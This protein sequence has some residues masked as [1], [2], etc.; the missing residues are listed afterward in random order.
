MN[1]GVQ[2]F[3]VRDY[4]GTKERVKDTFSKIKATAYDSVQS[5]GPLPCVSYSEFAAL[6]KDA[7]LKICATFEDF[8]SMCQN[9]KE[10]A[11]L[12][13]PYDTRIVGTAFSM[14]GDNPENVLAQL[15]LASENMWKEGYIFSYHNHE[16]EFSKYKNTNIMDYYIENTDPQKVTF[17]FDT[18]WAQ[19]G[20]ADVR[21]YI[22][23]LSG[24]LHT[25][26][27][28][29]YAVSGGRPMFAPVGSGNMYWDGII[30]SAKESGTEYF[31]VEQDECYGENPFEALKKSRD[32]LEK[33]I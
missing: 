11:E 27:L 10:I 3:T 18:F 31:L 4:L 32:F 24:R 28:K 19:Y 1:I 26:H 9:P 22:K 29:D 21:Y 23:K 33:Y 7:G 16:H 12:I 5:F 2:L 15:K 17:C 20:G 6:A 30:E 8:G 25:L 13:K 14:R